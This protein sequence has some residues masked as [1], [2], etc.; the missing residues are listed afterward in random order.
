MSD[1]LF[2]EA[3]RAAIADP[4]VP[5]S[6][7]YKLREV[8]IQVLDG[9]ESGI[10]MEYCPFTGVRLPSSLRDVWFDRLDELEMEPDDPD[11]PQEL[12]SGEW[13]RIAGL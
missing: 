5:V 8:T 12:R 10:L 9:G 11:L 6:Y 2:S 4:D 13:W 1:Q 7:N 3:L